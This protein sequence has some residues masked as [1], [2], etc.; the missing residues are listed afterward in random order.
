M[1][2]REKLLSGHKVLTAE[3]TPPHGPD[4]THFEQIGRVL[5]PHFDALNVTD[6]Q[7]ALM[8]MSNLATAAYLVRMGIEPIYQLTC[9]DRNSL[10]L[11]SDLMGAQALGI[12][13]VLCLT[14]DPVRAGHFTDA[15][16]V[17]E[18]ESVGLLKLIKNLKAGKNSAGK[19]LESPLQ[20]FQGAVVN[21]SVAS[22]AAQIRR[23]EK[24]IEAGANFFQT[25]AVFSM[26]TMEPFMKQISYLKVP[27]IAGVLLVRS[28]KTAKFLHEKVP[29]VFVPPELFDALEKAQDP[30]RAGIEYAQKLSRDLLSVCQ[31]VHLMAVKN[32]EAL[33][34]VVEGGKLRSL[35]G[36]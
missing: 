32:E 14:G 8:R 20:I 10:A 34:D 24:K 6:N 31:G 9:R 22:P 35:L 11:Q 12:P 13:N 29:G 7:R 26:A 28:L 27:V 25:Q 30:A 16:P 5:K 2:F 17:F 21:P 23:M 4:M 33:V 18:V 1:N 3:I 19:N 36:P 15:K